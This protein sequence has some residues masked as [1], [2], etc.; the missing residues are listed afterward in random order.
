MLNRAIKCSESIASK[1]PKLFPKKKRK[2]RTF[3][4]G[5]SPSNI[6]KTST[7]PRRKES[8]DRLGQT[9]DLHSM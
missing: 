8:E 6:A 7:T 1:Y 3:Q 5:S 2:Y 9:S 4:R